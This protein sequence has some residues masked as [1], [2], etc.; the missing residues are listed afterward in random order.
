MQLRGYA[1][2]PPPGLG[3]AELNLYNKLNEKFD[4]TELIIQDTSGELA[5]FRCMV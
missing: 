4:P 3:D 5:C 1:V 2:Q